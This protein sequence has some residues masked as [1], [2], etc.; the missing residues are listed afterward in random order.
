M[1]ASFRTQVSASNG[2]EKARTAAIHYK[3]AKIF[4]EQGYDATSMDDIAEALQI[5]K[6]GL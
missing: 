3:S 5:T 1:S 2:E 6:A 4:L